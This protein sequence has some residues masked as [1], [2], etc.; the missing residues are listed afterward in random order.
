MKLKIKGHQYT[1]TFCLEA[2]L[3]IRQYCLVFLNQLSTNSNF[4]LSHSWRFVCKIRFVVLT[5]NY[6]WAAY[7]DLFWPSW[8]GKMVM[9]SGIWCYFVY[10]QECTK[11]CFLDHRTNN[12]RQFSS[13]QHHV[14]QPALWEQ[15]HCHNSVFRVFPRL[16]NISSSDHQT[17]LSVGLLLLTL[18][19]FLPLC[20][21][22]ALTKC[23]CK[24][25]HAHAY[26]HTCIQAYAE[27]PFPKQ[28]FKFLTFA[29]I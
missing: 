20:Y 7:Y 25:I 8:E 29:F 18:F 12:Q 4:N 27:K 3:T 15:F 23:V 24:Y 28:Q 19:L 1:T 16:H 6:T 9:E 22:Q 13:S 17:F 14:T 2:L 11:A 10:S 26:T 5:V 21:A